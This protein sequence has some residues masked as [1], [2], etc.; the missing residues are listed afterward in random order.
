MYN[1]EDQLKDMCSKLPNKT[2]MQIPKFSD[3]V[4]LQYLTG[5]LYTQAQ[6]NTILSRVMEEYRHVDKTSI[7]AYSI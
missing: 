3:K 6:E 2:E 7:N 1:Q 4:Y 5:V